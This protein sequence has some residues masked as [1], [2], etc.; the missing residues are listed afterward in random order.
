[1]DNLLKV[2]VGAVNIH[3]VI[4]GCD[5]FK[6]VLEKYPLVVGVCGDAG[7]RGMFVEFVEGLGRRC[8][9]SDK[10]VPKGWVVLS[11]RW[12]VE[13]TF[14]WFIGRC[15]SKDCEISIRS[16]EDM[17]MFAHLATLFRRLCY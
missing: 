14:G 10:I 17:V 8:D 7:F 16:E 12:C 4:A 6:A 15:L 2:V 1:M 13:C 11:K 5:V 9:I 3:D